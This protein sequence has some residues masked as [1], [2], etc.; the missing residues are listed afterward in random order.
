MALVAANL[1]VAAWAVWLTEP[2]RDGDGKSPSRSG[3]PLSSAMVDSGECFATPWSTDLGQV[4]V[5]VTNLRAQ[6]Y[7]V[8]T[9]EGVQQIQVGYQVTAPGRYHVQEAG[10][11]AL[12]AREQGFAAA[13]ATVG[14][15]GR[16]TVAFSSHGSWMDAETARLA[17]SRSGF[18]AEIEPLYRTSPTVRAVLMSPM[19]RSSPVNAGGQWETVDCQA[20]SW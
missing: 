20:L 16:P 9:E 5:L 12:R 17:L 6:G 7:V 1:G 14:A 4:W 2:V 8:G 10:R 15:D 18:A 13:A 19:G 3:E 11:I